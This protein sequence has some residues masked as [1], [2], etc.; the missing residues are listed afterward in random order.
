MSRVE[1]DGRAVPVV[2]RKQLEQAD[3]HGDVLLASLP[4]VAPLDLTEAIT[5]LA[6]RHLEYLVDPDNA[7]VER[8]YHIAAQLGWWNVLLIRKIQQM[9]HAEFQEEKLVVPPGD[10]S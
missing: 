6:Q 9:V 8:L 4:K 1:V 5:P 3:V 2:T 7:T 10:A